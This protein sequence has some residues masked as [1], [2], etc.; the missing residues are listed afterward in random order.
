MLAF[1][2]STLLPLSIFACAAE[3]GAGHKTGQNNDKKMATK[4]TQLCRVSL[5]FVGLKKQRQV[6]VLFF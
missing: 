5:T 1:C 3:G 2:V 4:L 6:I